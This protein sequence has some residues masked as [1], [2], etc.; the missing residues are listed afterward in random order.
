[1]SPMLYQL[2]YRDTRVKDAKRPQIMQQ[3][4]GKKKMH[5][6]SRPDWVRVLP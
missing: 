1:M 4:N 6:V 5:S 2:S 3:N